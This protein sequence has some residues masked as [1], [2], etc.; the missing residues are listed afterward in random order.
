MVSSQNS[1]A[2]TL[3]E[4]SPEKSCRQHRSVLPALTRLLGLSKGAS[5]LQ[6]RLLLLLLLQSWSGCKLGIYSGVIAVSTLLSDS[7]CLIGPI[8]AA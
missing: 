2:A 5:K 1:I 3:V 6:L 8:A 7:R 4:T